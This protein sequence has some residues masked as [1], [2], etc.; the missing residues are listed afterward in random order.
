MRLSIGWLPPRRPHDPYLYT[1]AE[2]AALTA[3]ARRARWPL[4]G[5][6]YETL[7]GLLG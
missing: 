2:I 6:T 5:A 1:E 4:S 7:I 3:A